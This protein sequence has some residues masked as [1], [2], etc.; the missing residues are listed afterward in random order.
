MVFADLSGYEPG[1]S[2]NFVERAQRSCQDVRER[3][4]GGEERACSDRSVLSTAVPRQWRWSGCRRQATSL[5]S[6]TSLRQSG[7]T[8]ATRPAPPPAPRHELR[9]RVLMCWRPMDRGTSWWLALRSPSRRTLPSHMR[10]PVLF[11]WYG[12]FVCTFGRITLT[13][14][15]MFGAA[16]SCVARL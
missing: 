5:T 3:R 13:I 7:S 15:I 14:T 12:L 6:S 2:K 4:E 10:S 1:S 16:P 11:S 9:E 8:R